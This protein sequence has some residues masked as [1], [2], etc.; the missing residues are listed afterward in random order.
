M[1]PTGKSIKEG[2][3][4]SGYQR[5]SDRQHFLICHCPLEGIYG[6]QNPSTIVLRIPF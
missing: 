1:E 3:G 4:C 5:T 6:K 2:L